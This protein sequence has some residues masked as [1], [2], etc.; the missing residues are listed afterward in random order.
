MPISPMSSASRTRR[1]LRPSYEHEPCNSPGRALVCATGLIL[2]AMGAMAC[3]D[4]SVPAPALEQMMTRP[5][6]PLSLAP[7]PPQE[8]PPTPIRPTPEPVEPVDDNGAGATEGRLTWR[9]CGGLVRCSEVPVP[10]DRHAPEGDMIEVAINRVE[11][12]PVLAHRGVV[13]INQGGPG[14]SGK[15]FVADN[16]SALR[17]LFPGFDVVGFDPRGVGDSAPLDCP[18]E[19]DPAVTYRSQGVGAVITSIRA[20]AQRCEQATGALFHHLGSHEV[21]ADVDHIRAALGEDQITFI[22]LSYGT[23]LAALYAQTFPDRVRALVL[24]APMRP[25]A[26]YVDFI[27][28][29]FEATL[30]VHEDFFAACADGALSCP[31]EAEAAF[32]TLMATGLESGLSQEQLTYLWSA[33]LASSLGRDAAAELLNQPEI[34]AQVAMQDLMTDMTSQLNIALNLSVHCADDTLP[35]PSLEEAEALMASFASRS[36]LFAPLGVPSLYC[37]GW[38]PAPDP[39]ELQTFERSALVLG[40]VADSRTPLAWALEMSETLRGSTFVRSE[41]YGHG[42]LG[43]GG[44]CVAQALVDYVVNSK[45]PDAGTVCPAP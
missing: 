31:L 44:E 6:P 39:V 25:V 32:E 13:I 28:G 43:N 42:A 8:P 29:Q 30:Q 1:G 10:L 45:L 21:V 5:I 11:A 40:G 26:S 33:L 12:S 36:P 38:R 20:Q 35:P 9:F 14:Y 24:D 41:H 34:L 37:A 2:M 22:G 17:A 3:G 15:A 18:L 27:Q 23:R 19:D 4:E 16:A 7:Q